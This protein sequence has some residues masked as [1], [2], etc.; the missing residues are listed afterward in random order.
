MSYTST[1]LPYDAVRITFNVRTELRMTDPVDGPCLERAVATAMTRYPYLCRRL[2][3]E[4]GA[5]RFVAN[6]RPIAVQP[7]T[8]TPGA[9][10]TPA[11]NEQLISVDYHDNVIAVNACHMLAGGYGQFELIRTIVY[12]YVAERYGVTPQVPGIRLAGESIP[13]DERAFP[14][15]ET[16]PAAEPPRGEAPADGAFPDADYELLAREPERFFDCYYQLEFDQAP[17]MAKAKAVNGTPSS[18]FSALMFRALHRAW[19]DRTLPIQVAVMH[20]FQNQVGCPDSTCDLVRGLLLRYPDSM[21]DASLRELCTFSRS[22]IAQQAGAENA[23]A[24]TRAALERLAEV[25]KRK[26][27]REKL[28]YCAAHPF[29]GAKVKSSCVVA[30]TGRTEWGD[31]RRYI[32]S[33]A[34]LTDGHPLLEILSLGDKLFVGFQQILRD[35]KYIDALCR[36]LE[37]EEIPYKVSGPFPKTVPGLYLPKE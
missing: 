10:N 30:Y 29:I 27:L 4:D 3:L 28:D 31:L 17:F 20:N 8:G 26:T 34:A 15:M 13:D 7:F 21:A 35:T 11:V 9:L 2:V 5:Y 14:T 32:L 23:I 37:E 33:D 16:L 25:E 36:A 6:D 24:D 18:L 1:L 19:P 22:V 12:Y